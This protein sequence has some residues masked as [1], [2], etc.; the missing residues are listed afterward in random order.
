MNC[1]VIPRIAIEFG[2]VQRSQ[3]ICILDLALE[4]TIVTLPFRPSNCLKTHLL[5]SVWLAPKRLSASSLR[6]LTNARNSVFATNRKERL[7]ETTQRT[8]N[9]SNLSCSI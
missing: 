3:L 7:Q 9:A 5:T 8:H 2:E 6:Y 4:R 1:A